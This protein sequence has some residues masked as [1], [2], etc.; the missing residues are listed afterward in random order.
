[1][2]YPGRK[3][4][5][6]RKSVFPHMRVDQQSDFGVEIAKRGKRGERHSNQIAD[7]ADIEND[8]I[9]P[10]FEQTAAEKSDHRLKVLPLG[11]GGVNAGKVSALFRVMR[12]N[13]VEQV[14]Q[15]ESRGRNFHA[16]TLNDLLGGKVLAVERLV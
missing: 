8:L 11:R 1:M 10:F 4:A 7:A 2:I 12:R 9:G 14:N 15:G 13:F 5:V 6:K 16:T 3:K